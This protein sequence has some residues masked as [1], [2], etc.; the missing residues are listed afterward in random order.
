MA[1]SECL[2]YHHTCHEQKPG[3]YFRASRYLSGHPTER[4]SPQ[5]GM[6]F[7]SW[8]CIKKY[9]IYRA[10]RLCFLWHKGF[11]SWISPS[12][13]VF[14][15]DPW[16]FPSREGTQG[17]ELCRAHIYKMNCTKRCVP[18]VFTSWNVQWRLECAV[19]R[20]CGWNV[21]WGMVL[22]PYRGHNRLRVV[23]CASFTTNSA[24]VSTEREDT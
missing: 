8:D 15:E 18:W 22:I 7:A 14:C 19:G 11:G 5:P 23:I 13:W 24:K 2:L 16:G 17:A 3:R 21:Q 4:G 10:I 1:G 20:N 12:L 6:G 9:N